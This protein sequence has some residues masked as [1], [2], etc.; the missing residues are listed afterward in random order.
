MIE[1]EMCFIEMSDLI[2]IS[3]DYIK[4]CIKYC[5]DNYSDEIDFFTSKY[6]ET[7]REELEKILEKPFT[8][9]TYT[10]VIETLLTEIGNGNAIIRDSKM[11]NRKFKKLAK[12]K[13]VFE[14]GIYWGC[15]L[16]SEHEKY[17]TDKI[18]EGPLVVTDY[19]KEIK[20]FYMKENEDGKT[21]QAMDILVPN[22]GE[23]VGGSMREEDYDALKEKMEVRFAN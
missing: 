2:D 13:H 20:S 16:A 15:D 10:K 3:E 14:E 1:P 18:I 23:L 17:M 5:L 6:R 12:G 4:Y 8:R 21:V 7:L 11:E 9:M 22:I 19:P